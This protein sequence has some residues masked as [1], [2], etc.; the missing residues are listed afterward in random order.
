[1]PSETQELLFKAALMPSDVAVSAWRTWNQRIDLVKNQLEGDTFRI[2]P[3]VNENLQGYIADDPHGARLK[4]ISRYH[5]TKTQLVLRDGAKAVEILNMAGIPTML[6]KGAA[7]VSAGMVRVSSRSMADVDVLIP[8]AFHTQALALLLEEGWKVK[9]QI[10]PSR[11]RL[12]HSLDLQL[13]GSTGLDL[14]WF[15]LSEGCQIGLDDDFW[16]GSVTTMLKETPTLRLNDSD[17]L[18]HVLAHGARLELTPSHHWVVDAVTILRASSSIEWQRV[19]AMAERRNMT[20]Q[21]AAM[22]RYLSHTF[23]VSVSESIFTQL[24]SMRPSLGQ[25]IE[26][27]ARSRQQAR[28]RGIVFHTHKYWR[29][30]HGAQAMHLSLPRY[31][32][33]W[34]GI[35]RQRDLP[36]V[37]LKRGLRQIIRFP[38]HQI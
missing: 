20:L 10:P 15:A 33:D 8:P 16:S 9:D 4:G 5:W 3:T 14:H 37:V 27:W 7:M 1:M 35:P 31:L 36:S 28:W 38:K 26:Y 22:L 18:L 12:I 23:E 2:F 11:Y 29:L 13:N 21:L 34:W 32:Q 24:A 30:T 25:R 19:I 17:L 6:L